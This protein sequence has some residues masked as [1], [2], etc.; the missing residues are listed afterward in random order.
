MVC[1]RCGGLVVVETFTDMR[2][3]ISRGSFLGSRCLNC[4]HIEDPV[5]FSNRSCPLSNRWARRIG[6]SVIK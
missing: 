3:E 2:E 1:I 5:I 4:G 6:G